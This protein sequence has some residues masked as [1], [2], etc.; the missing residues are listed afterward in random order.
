VLYNRGAHAG[1]ALVLTKP[2]GTGLWGTALKRGVYAD[3]HPQAR[4]AI[5]SM[6]RLNKAAA[7]AAQTLQQEYKNGGAAQTGEYVHACTDVT[8][9]GLLGHLHEMAAASGLSAVLQLDALPLL[10]LAWELSADGVRPGRTDDLITWSREFSSFAGA[11]GEGT[12][13]AEAER[14]RDIWEGIICDPQTSGGLLLA[15]APEAT[16]HYLALLPPEL[17]ARHIGSFETGLAG[18]LRLE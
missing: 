2:L 12:G 4:I 16:T 11:L 14:A 9:F 3:D 18:H 7:E 10:P 15:L 6:A 1:D 5:E 8:G 13:G 17:E